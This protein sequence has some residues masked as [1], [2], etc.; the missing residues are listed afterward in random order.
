MLISFTH[1]VGEREEYIMILI[2]I[3]IR[4]FDAIYVRLELYIIIENLLV[5]IQV[6]SLRILST[7]FNSI[8][9]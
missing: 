2:L 7:K 1:S 3:I 9:T 6:H 8:Y 5:Y 4:E